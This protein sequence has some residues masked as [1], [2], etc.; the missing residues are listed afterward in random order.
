MR[1]FRN[2]VI[3]WI[4]WIAFFNSRSENKKMNK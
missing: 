4:L 3:I 2:N 1:V